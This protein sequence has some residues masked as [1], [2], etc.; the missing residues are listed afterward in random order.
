MVQLQPTESDT[1]T[2]TRISSQAIN[3]PINL[4]IEKILDVLCHGMRCS[5]LLRVLDIDDAR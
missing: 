2:E 3:I 4:G 1:S 5:F